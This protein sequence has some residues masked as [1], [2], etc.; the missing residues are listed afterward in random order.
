MG[1]GW[2]GD[3]AQCRGH[4]PMP[5]VPG[6]QVPGCRSRNT[7][8]TAQFRGQRRSLGTQERSCRDWA[9]VVCNRGC[10]GDRT[11]AGKPEL[12]KTQM[13]GPERC[14]GHSPM[15]AEVPGTQPNSG[16]TGAVVP[17]A[18]VSGL[19][20]GVF[21]RAELGLESSSYG[22]GKWAGRASLSQG[23]RRGDRGTWRLSSRL[24]VR[25][26]VGEDPS[27]AHRDS[28][29]AKKSPLPHSLTVVALD[30]LASGPECVFGGRTRA[31]KPELRLCSA[32]CSVRGRDRGVLSGG[33]CEIAVQRG[34]SGRRR[35]WQW[36]SPVNLPVR[37]V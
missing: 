36:R 15:P 26:A 3:T 8:D 37:V 6:T 28:S 11:R 25:P 4:S 7:G 9:S 35:R 13:C 24:R 17:C 20:P 21:F 16:D 5:G 2:L 31:G 12:R 23:V 14:R 29:T 33:R 34:A 30:C 18:C 1:A 27:R 22:K 19:Q 10:F 32:G